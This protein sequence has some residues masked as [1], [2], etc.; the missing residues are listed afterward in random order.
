MGIGTILM[1][2]LLVKDH[3]GYCENC[4]WTC[5]IKNISGAFTCPMCGDFG[6]P[7]YYTKKELQKE[8]EVV[9]NG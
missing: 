1:E 3:V 8:P 5:F 7:G 6:F 4:G 2:N 9:I